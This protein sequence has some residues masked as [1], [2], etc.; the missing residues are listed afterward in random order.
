MALGALAALRER[1]LSVPGDISL[2]G[3][4]NSAL[5]KS[6]FLDIT[7]I[8]NRSDLVGKGV[9]RALLARLQDPS[10]RPGRTLINPDLVLR[11]TTGRPRFPT[12][13]T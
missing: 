11:S 4:D 5:A 3:Y 8:D 12:L 13:D 7:T 10:L 1:G 2:I 6:R 9:A